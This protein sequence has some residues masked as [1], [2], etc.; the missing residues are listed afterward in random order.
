MERPTQLDD[1][2]I[3]VRVVEHK[4]MSAAARRLGVPKSTISRAITRLED[5]L[6]V[7]LLQ[8]TTRA[9]APTE[10]GSALYTEVMPHVEALRSATSVVTAESETPRGLIRVTAPNDLAAALLP[11][12]VARFTKRYPEVQVDLVLTA[13]TVDLI[14][15]NVDIAI[16]AGTLRDSTLIARKLREAESHVCAAP[17]YLAVHGTPKTPADIASHECIL[18]R[19]Q[20]GR[21]RWTL[22]SK[23]DK[24]SVDAKGRVS[25]DDFG[26]V[27]GAAIA[28]MGLAL[29]PRFLSAA[30]V[31]DGRLVRVLPTYTLKGGAM[32]AVHAST[33]HLPRKIAVFRDFLIE[34][35]AALSTI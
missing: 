5:G 19:P 1:L 11:E 18:F 23:N 15:E 34:S 9:L 8:R 25:C 3:F 30:A 33:R 27:L 17:S 21:A 14:A 16:R 35:F 7:R 10:A 32:Y 20:N 4:S 28:G 13:R 6:K 2:G 12:I 26:F 29:I 24:V 31:A 22:E